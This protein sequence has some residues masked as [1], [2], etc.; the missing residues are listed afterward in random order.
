[1]IIN[2]EELEKLKFEFA[3][4]SQ[5]LADLSENNDEYFIE[6]T[7]NTNKLKS[8]LSSVIDQDA[9]KSS[10]DSANSISKQVDYFAKAVFDLS[11]SFVG[12][13][14]LESNLEASASKFSSF[15]TSLENFSKSPDQQAGATP[16][17]PRGTD[18]KDDGSG[19]KDKPG[20]LKQNLTGAF[21][22]VK[23]AIRPLQLPTSLG[24]VAGTAVAWMAFGVSEAQRL[25]AQAGEATNMLVAAVDG[26]GKKAVTTG[27]KWLSLYAEK[28]D[29]FYGIS[30]KEVMG[31]AK[32]FAHMGFSIDDSINKKAGPAIEN[33][34]G[35]FMS[36]S[37][38]LDKMLEQATGTNAAKMG[39]YASKYGMSLGESSQALTKMYALGKDSG[40]IG[41]ITFLTNVEKSSDALSTMGYKISEVIDSFEVLRKRF[42]AVGVPKY[43][44]A[45]TVGEGIKGITEGMQNAGAS[46][47][48]VMAEWAGYGTG[49]SAR[50]KML[51]SMSK[52]SDDNK[53]KWKQDVLN[54]TR[55]AINRMGVTKARDWL[56]KKGSMGFQGALVAAELVAA[57]DSGDS[58]TSGNL[59]KAEAA[60]EK[61][62][63]E[64][65][66]ALKTESTKMNEMK[67]LLNKWKV[68]QREIGQGMM[69]L[70]VDTI[71][72]LFA[73]FKSVPTIIGT[74]L[75]DNYEKGRAEREQILA[76]V[77]SFG[78]GV[79][80]HFDLVIHGVK[81]SLGSAGG[82]IVAA[83]G[84]S[85]DT[86]LD[87]YNF[88][89]YKDILGMTQKKGNAN[90]SVGGS[91]YGTSPITRVVTVPI[92][93]RDSTGSSNVEGLSSI[94]LEASRAML[95]Y[96]LAWR[97]LKLVTYGV[98]ESGGLRMGIEGSCPRCGLLFARGGRSPG[99][100]GS[101]RGS[102]ST[103]ESSLMNPAS[104]M[105]SSVFSD[106]RF[107]KGKPAMELKS[108]KDEMA[109]AAKDPEQV[110][111]LASML[112]SEVGGSALKTKEGRREL[113]GVAH[114]AINRLGGRTKNSVMDR[115][116][117]G[118]SGRMG[119]ESR[120]NKTMQDV[121]LGT[122]G[123]KGRQKGD[124]RPYAS[125]NKDTSSKQ[126]HKMEGFA[127]DILEGNVENEVGSATQFVHET[128]GR[129]YNLSHKEMAENRKARK[130]GK[131]DVHA[132]N[133][134]AN[135]QTNDSNINTA[136]IQR[137]GKPAA[138]F[139]GR[140]GLEA[141]DARELDEAQTADWEGAHDSD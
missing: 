7:N 30:E 38:S 1:M 61:F 102:A 15:A 90:W 31:L 8:N 129:G 67:R 83:M 64:Q 137:E 139:Y 69:G 16:G 126:F 9:L 108:V 105:P 10:V 2:F 132:G 73:F 93:V 47:Q 122:S 118:Y 96:N 29:K 120:A 140:S 76:K 60:M 49:A 123:T 53:D 95:D 141:S 18:T 86:A 98:T 34:H 55:T 17:A 100:V 40:S 80:A 44:A 36:V 79:P 33:L 50:Q 62:R 99:L 32:Q 77:A 41:S 116:S 45:S 97:T 39:D 14:S 65:K 26:A 121:I 71:A 42:E 92:P 117:A 52:L 81:A 107:K 23:T 13:E 103:V 58:G 74:Y 112:M 131:S 4:L 85:K 59:K 101:S 89:P 20:I 88:N 124:F 57:T 111:L 3:D 46:E 125:G 106:S 63:Q 75:Q 37:L 136:N 127:Q 135:L 115:A 110:K 68:G 5:A 66:E 119:G 54:V 87:A 48:V 94:A 19:K 56:S 133:P 11:L 130:A 134:L 113:A 109:A 22:A 28:M 27:T 35:N 43:L 78:S 114:T 70:A 21:D 25:K 82:M 24:A 104:G 84:K 6:I 128:G 51:D 138:R 12:M 91:G 72:V